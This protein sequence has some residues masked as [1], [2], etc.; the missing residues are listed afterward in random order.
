MCS[1]VEMPSTKR[2]MFPRNFSLN[3][4]Y[5]I[6]TFKNTRGFEHEQV[7]SY[8]SLGQC[9]LWKHK[10]TSFIYTSYYYFLPFNSK[11]K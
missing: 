9:P 6:P 3:L 5:V 8:A 11:P 7:R 10:D 2:N 4:Q 1:T